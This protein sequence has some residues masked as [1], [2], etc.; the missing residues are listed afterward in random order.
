MPPRFETPLPERYA[1]QKLREDKTATVKHF[2]EEKNGRDRFGN[3]L[4]RSPDLS[5]FDRDYDAI[6]ASLLLSPFGERLIKSYPGLL[7]EIERGLIEIENTFQ[8]G[9]MKPK[10]WVDLSSGAKLKALTRGG[11]SKVYVLEIGE[12]KYI[13]KTEVPK[14]RHFG[15]VSQPYINEMLQAQ[16]IEADLREEL[17][18]LGIKM[19]TFL[20]ASGQVSCIKF[21]NGTEP[22]QEEVLAKASKLVE[23]LVGYIKKKQIEKDELWKNIRIDLANRLKMAIKTDNFIKKDDGSYVWIDP[24]YY[25]DISREH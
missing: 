24:F 21:E 4:F 1:E 14:M 5:Y 11:Q 15:D 22:S 23:L 16:S 12:E 8:E 18:K 20:F 3:R 25:E 10:E 7:K 17:N 19:P 9:T 2:K 6:K 13:L